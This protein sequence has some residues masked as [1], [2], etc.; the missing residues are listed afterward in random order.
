MACVSQAGLAISPSS[1]QK[2]W[3]SRTGVSPVLLYQTFCGLEG[4]Q[5]CFT[6]PSDSKRDTSPAIPN[7]L[8]VRETPALIYQTF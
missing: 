4:H 1:H 2:V 5:S 6:K 7:L 8:I 3:Y